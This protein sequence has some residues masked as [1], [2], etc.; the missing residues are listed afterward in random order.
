[1]N[2]SQDDHRH[3]AALLNGWRA[4]LNEALKTQ[5]AAANRAAALRKAIDGVE[6]LYPNLSNAVPVD[7]QDITGS[8]SGD[9]VEELTAADLVREILRNEPLRWFATGDMV[10]EFR[11]RGSEATPEAIRLAL[12]RTAGKETEHRMSEK[13]RVFRLRAAQSEDIDVLGGLEQ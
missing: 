8:D 7:F 10:R 6:T 9:V 3:T 1:M 5:I 13:G 2:N 12:R 11:T 4:E